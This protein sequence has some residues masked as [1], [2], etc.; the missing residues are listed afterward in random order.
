M[1]S[2][3]KGYVDGMAFHWYIYNDDRYLDGSYGYDSVNYSY[4]AAPDKILLATEGC[5][6]PGVLIDN[7]SRAERLVHDITFDMLNYAQG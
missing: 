3:E 5:S 4:H 7:W 6:C 2:N 1:G